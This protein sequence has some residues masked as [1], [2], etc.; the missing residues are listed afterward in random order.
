MH[1]V[2]RDTTV[3][4]VR[5]CIRERSRLRKLTRGKEDLPR[6]WIEWVGCSNALAMRLGGLDGLDGLN[7]LDLSD[8]LGG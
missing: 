5:A 3:R 1:V 7:G 4:D 8:G 2:V 6:Q